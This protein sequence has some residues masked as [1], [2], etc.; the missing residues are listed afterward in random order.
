MYPVLLQNDALGLTIRTYPVTLAVAVVVGVWLTWH[1]A[2]RVEGVTPTR[3][4]RILLSLCLGAWVGGRLH[5]L[6]NSGSFA[7]DQIVGA[8]R[9]GEIFGTSFHAGG[10]ILGLLTAAFA[11]LRH[12]RIRPSQFGDAL[13]PGFGASL[14]IGRFA[15]FLNG[16]CTGSVCNLPWAV[17]FPRPAYVWNYHVYLGLVPGTSQWSAPV[18]PLQLYFTAVG[19]VIYL[20]GL[21]MERHKR[22]DGQSVLLALLLVSASN[23]VL[24]SFRGYA[25]LRRYWYGTPQLTWI[26]AA[27]TVA[28]ALVLLVRELQNWRGPM[29][30]E[31]THGERA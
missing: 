27:M 9:F 6:I 11:A 19:V 8:R 26:A 13:V 28:V 31:L 16:C 29:R 12:Y 1:R 18:H 24:E 3:L 2:L 17:S 10:A 25:P 30:P 4:R 21:W 15:C 20:L 14:A 23:A 22:Y 7:Y 5:F